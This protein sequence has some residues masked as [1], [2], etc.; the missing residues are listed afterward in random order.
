MSGSFLSLARECRQ[1]G[2]LDMIK[3]DLQK[4]IAKAHEE[5]AEGMA[6]YRELIAESKET[7]AALNK[8]VCGHHGFAKVVFIRYISH[9]TKKQGP[10]FR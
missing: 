9:R 7:I 5:E 1:V 4:D 10:P 2:I 6:A 3:E 8:K